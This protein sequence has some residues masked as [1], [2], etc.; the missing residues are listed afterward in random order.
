MG[1]VLFTLNKL[2]FVPQPS[3]RA[4]SFIIIIHHYFRNTT[5]HQV[6][7][8][9]PQE[10][11]LLHKIRNK[12]TILAGK[13]VLIVDDDVRNVFAL[14]ATLEDKEMEIVVA[15]NDQEALQVLETQADIKVILMDI[16]MP[17]MDSY[18]AI[19]Q[20]RSQPRFRQLPIIALTAKAMK[21]DKSK[22]I[23]AGASDYLAKPFDANKLLSLLRVWLHR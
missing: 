5:L 15:R 9:L 2:G 7:S 1:W 10:Q 17:G 14:A 3:L 23:E 4:I 12:E 21:G 8:Q 18:E 22:C 13:T 19:R 6:E 11:Q 16:M 20:I